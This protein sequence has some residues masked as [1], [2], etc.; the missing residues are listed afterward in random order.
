MNAGLK[1]FIV[2]DMTV[3]EASFVSERMQYAAAAACLLQLVT[4][5][6]ECDI[7]TLAQGILGKGGI[8]IS[9]LLGS[10]I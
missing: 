10:F 6:A 9:A 3:L 7:T 4:R 2:P 5:L 8:S 1:V